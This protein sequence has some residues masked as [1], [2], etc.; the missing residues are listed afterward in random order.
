VPDRAG[1]ELGRRFPGLVVAGAYA[2]PAGFDSAAAGIDAV[3]RRIGA[4]APAVVFVGLGFP[5]QERLIAQL[6]PS[7]PATWFVGCG[8]AIPFAAGVLPRAPAWM[9]RSG[10]EWTFRLASEPRRLFRR[11]V[12]HDLPFAASIFASSAAERIQPHGRPRRR[13]KVS[14]GSPARRSSSENMASTLT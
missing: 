2:P 12:L 3:R 4:A 8:A 11:Y 6:A 7:F 14:L 1:V 13:L 9:Q 5:K 10:L